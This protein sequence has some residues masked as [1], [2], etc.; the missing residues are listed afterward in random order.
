MEDKG[1][2]PELMH[3]EDKVVETDSL[4][5]QLISE[6]YTERPDL[7]VDAME[8]YDPGCTKEINTQLREQLDL[9]IQAQK[10]L[11]EFNKTNA[12]RC[13]YQSEIAAGSVILAIFVL[14][15]MKAATFFNIL[16][17]GIL[18]AITQGGE[19]GFRKIAESVGDIASRF[20]G[21]GD[22]GGG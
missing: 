22:K 16:A 12:Y 7:L 11:A 19:I 17:L 14:I 10:D 20:K 1:K 21:G 13:M 6:E 5:V 18:Y 3:P 9:E 8:K 4:L 2:E 15:I